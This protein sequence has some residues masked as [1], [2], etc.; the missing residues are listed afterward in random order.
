MKEKET[1]DPGDFSGSR[2]QQQKSL[3]EKI[4]PGVISSAEPKG[5]AGE[6]LQCLI[7]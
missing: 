2:K 7:W 6:A 4:R 3:K 5:D 1:T